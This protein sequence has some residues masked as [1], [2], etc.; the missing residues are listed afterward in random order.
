MYKVY[1]VELASGYRESH[2][3]NS[4]FHSVTLLPKAGRTY[5]VSISGVNN[6]GE[7]SRSTP[8]TFKIPEVCDQFF[9][10]NT[11]SYY[12]VAG[13]GALLIALLATCVVLLCKKTCCR[14]KVT[15]CRDI[16][17]RQ[18]SLSTLKRAEHGIRNINLDDIDSMTDVNSEMQE[19]D[20][21]VDDMRHQYQH[22]REPVYNNGWVFNSNHVA[23]SQMDSQYATLDSIGKSSC[24]SLSSMSQ[25]EEHSTMS[26]LPRRRDEVVPEQ[27][28]AYPYEVP[29][30]KGSS[31]IQHIYQSVD[32]AADD[33]L[34]FRIHANQKSHSVN[35]LPSSI[36]SSTSTSRESSVEPRFAT[37]GPRVGGDGG[38][39]LPPLPEYSPPPLRRS[40]LDLMERLREE[41]DPYNSSQA[42][43]STSSHYRASGRGGSVPDILDIHSPLC[44]SDDSLANHGPTQTPPPNFY[45]ESTPQWMPSARI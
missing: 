36:P 17:D 39:S 29:S 22:Q 34:P 2:K 20:D 40:T 10:C 26:S 33:V 9:F 4:S 25:E 16:K 15:Y 41:S 43:L 11:Y 18:V 5:N 31:E 35:T 3:I 7:G 21:E 44:L 32:E 13:G 42:P 1:V 8:V 24:S 37:L 19:V 6:V 23:Q 30:R 45:Y 14:R 28:V 12:V 27:R 38:Y